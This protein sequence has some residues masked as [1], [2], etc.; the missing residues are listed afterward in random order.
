MAPETILNQETT[1]RSDLYGLGVL[2]YHLVSGSYPVRASSI[3]EL[4]ERHRRREA[5]LLRDARS[6]LPEAFVH[7]VERAL[8]WE[9]ERRFGSAGEMERA[10]SDALAIE[11]PAPSPP[12]PSIRTTTLLRGLPRWPMAAI[13]AMAVATL[14]LLGWW[15]LR[16][17]QRPPSLPPDARATATV[18]YEICA[19]LYRVGQE[20]RERLTSGDRLAIGDKL[21]LEIEGTVPLHVYVFNE[22]ER[23]ES[24]AL[25]PLP[26]LVLQNPL[27]AEE[28]HLL[29]GADRHET[30]DSW[31]VTSAGGREHL[32]VLASPEPLLEIEAE[33]EKLPRP[34]PGAAAMPV[35][36]DA[37]VRLRGIGGV[38]ASAGPAS[39]ASAGR[40]F[41]IARRLAGS[42]ERIEG[43][44]MRQIE[45]LNPEQ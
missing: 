19:A 40:L 30:Y 9:P 43:V 20:D 2:L 34:R 18:S 1:P 22:D 32:V 29:P 38:A 35:P 15:I 11:R 12:P 8:A 3:R 14:G 33:L 45:L 36:E 28:R 21:A 41:E 37:M 31:K 13:A 25:F 44:W 17:E 24:Y 39:E 27:P 10:L 26:D 16:E 4:A 42:P 7:V 5:K 23:G 6:D